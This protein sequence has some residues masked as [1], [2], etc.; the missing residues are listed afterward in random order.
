MKLLEHINLDK[1][2]VAKVKE[3]PNERDDL[4]NYFYSGLTYPIKNF[5]L[6]QIKNR[7]TVG[8]NPFGPYKDSYT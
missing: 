5:S 2:K 4:E 3:I 7:I 6:I 8:L 1:L